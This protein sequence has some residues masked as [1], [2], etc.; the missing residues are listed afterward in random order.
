MI[1][2]WLCKRRPWIIIFKFGRSCT[3]L[4]DGPGVDPLHW[5]RCTYFIVSSRFKIKN[6]FFQK[7]PYFLRNIYLHDIGLCISY[8]V[9]KSSFAFSIARAFNLKLF[10]TK[11]PLFPLLINCYS[12]HTVAINQWSPLN[13][14]IEIN[15]L[16]ILPGSTFEVTPSITTDGPQ[17]GLLVGATPIVFLT[18]KSPKRTSW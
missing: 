1:L 7:L 14:K 4:E 13:N 11:S 12:N 15:K 18:S 10:K 3:G 6:I 9:H 2:N 5:M 16:F 17:R 8:K